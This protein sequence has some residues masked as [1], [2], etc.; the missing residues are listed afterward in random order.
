[1]FTL[2][3]ELY[4]YYQP[5]EPTPT[6]TVVAAA[7]GSSGPVRSGSFHANLMMESVFF[8]DE[9]ERSTLLNTM[10]Q[11]FGS[12][13]I[14]L[15]SYDQSNL[16]Q[17]LFNF[18]RYMDGFYRERNDQPSSSSSGSFAQ[19]SFNEYH[20]SLFIVDHSRYV[21]GYALVNNIPYLE[22]KSDDL[23]KSARVEA[24]RQFYQAAGIKTA[25]FMG[26]N[27]GEIELGFSDQSQVNIEMEMR[28][29][30]PDDFSR[31][32]MAAT[33]REHHHPQLTE[34]NKPE[35]S[36][37]SLRSLSYDSPE[38][39]P[40]LQI[41]M[42]SE[43]Q[44]EPIVDPQLG[45]V[46]ALRPSPSIFT[47]TSCL[48]QAHISQIRSPQ[49]P[50]IESEDAAMANAILAVICSSTS[51]NPNNNNNNNNS[52][53]AASSSSNFS[54]QPQQNL[55]PNRYTVTSTRGGGGRQS[56]FQWYGSASAFA[57]RSTSSP[58]R[59]RRQNMLKRSLSFLRSINAMRSQSQEH[60]MQ[61]S[62]RTS[63][64]QLH[65][66]ISERRRREKLN[67]SF[68]ALR[69][70]LPPGTKKDKASVLTGTTEYLSSLKAEVEELSKRNATLEAQLLPK[71]TVAAAGEAI[72]SSSSPNERYYSEVGITQVS[73]SASSQSS[74]SSSTMGSAR[75]IDLHVTRVGEI[76]ITDMV[77]RLLE[78]L[79]RSDHHQSVLISLMSIEANTTL[80]ES[81][82]VNR[83][84][85]RLKIQGEWD[86]SAFQEA[87]RRVVNDQTQ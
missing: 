54:F 79:K 42:S 51:N 11:Y 70:L 17:T 36:S 77:V 13:Y 83:I 34:Q 25:V 85:L 4:N 18:L 33:T 44:Q 28:N 7:S 47:T 71:K 87:V 38:Y 63:S 53:S 49:I 68:Q 67:E 55:P 46:P 81:N 8:L 69:S 76:S 78:L 74:S 40:F 23:L 27:A 50:S 29:W 22:L 3:N 57:P 60:N 14:C 26:C 30:F 19:V 61:T 35:S 10:M 48:H 82:S 52:P 65:H 5:S 64:T 21:P 59:F 15:W 62:C 37:S 75:L 24:Q 73:E 16:P 45:A 12:T 20:Q 1:M 6:P 41:G 43:K 39:P 84:V 56:A 31:Q 9:G 86:E 80:E 58:S 72:I 66:M 32:L 2:S